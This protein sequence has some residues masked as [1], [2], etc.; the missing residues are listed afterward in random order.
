MRRSCAIEDEAFLQ[1]EARELA[2]LAE[3]CTGSPAKNRLSSSVLHTLA[4]ELSVLLGLGDE[5]RMEWLAAEAIRLLSAQG[6][7][8]AVSAFRATLSRLRRLSVLP[9]ALPSTQLMGLR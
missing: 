6:K 4:V 2:V 9:S 3:E 5:A 1:G 7:H 8:D